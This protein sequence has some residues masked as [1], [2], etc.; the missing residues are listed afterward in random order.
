[1]N[2]G[3]TN[4]L[5]S[6]T[7]DVTELYHWGLKKGEE[8]EKHKYAAR[9]KL[10]NG[11]YRYFYTLKEYQSYLKNKA[12]KV[13]DGVLDFISDSLGVKAA[14]S[15]EDAKANYKDSNRD[16]SYAK[17]QLQVIKDKANLDGKLS[18]KEKKQIAQ[19]QKSLKSAKKN[20]EKAEKEYK[21]TM[22]KYGSTP[23]STLSKTA[24]KVTNVGKKVVSSLLGRDSSEKK[25]YKYVAKVAL[26]NGKYR[27]FYSKDEYESYLKRLQYQE[28]SPDFMKDV[29][30][31]S[32]NKIFTSEEDMEKINEKYS[33]YSAKTSSNCSNCSAAYELRRRGYDVEALDNGGEDS[34]NG[35]L[36]RVYDYFENANLRFVNDDGS[37]LKGTESYIND[38]TSLKNRL[39]HNKE[40][41]WATTNHS[42]TGES[43][44]KAI[45]DNN[46]PGSRGFIDVGWSGSNAA[47]SLVYEVDKKGNVTIRDSQIDVSYS[48][49]QLAKQIRFATIT[50]TDNLD[51][52]KEIKTAVTENKD[53][54]RKYKAEVDEYGRTII[55]YN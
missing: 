50:R 1:M 4:F 44:T 10:K 6:R 35:N 22:K 13:K 3:Y 21:K 42:Y 38:S 24:S 52:K 5:I 31:I 18:K 29:S 43:L 36:G 27:Y 15:Y 20:K 17:S 41:Q 46:P 37:T 49:D 55:S 14:V 26:S 8:A 2:D 34:Y 19:Y 45:T 53:N 11:K 47:H 16:Y 25:K 51:L 30:K 23:M 39:K 28:D 12:D 7:P 54:Q 32:K 33:P 48:V 9:V 40:D